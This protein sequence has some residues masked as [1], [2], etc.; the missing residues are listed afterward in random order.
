[1]RYPNDFPALSPVPPEPDDVAVGMLQ[2]APSYG[3]CEVLL[4]SDEHEKR[5]WQLPDEH[6]FKLGEMWRETY[7]DFQ[8]DSKIAYT[9][10]FENRGEAVGV[11]MPHPHGQVYGYP[12]APEKVK[13]EHKNSAKY[14]RK[15]GSCLF[16][17]IL[18]SE[19]NDG[20]RI[21]FENEHFVVY[22]PFFA[23]TVYGVY[24]APKRHV[25]SIAEMTNA[26][27]N[28]L[29]KTVSRCSKMYDNLFDGGKIFPYMMGMYNPLKGAD[30]DFWH[31]HIKFFSVMR[32][33]VKQQFPASSETCVGAYCNP[34][35]PEE[36]AEELRK[37]AVL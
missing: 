25:F 30:K 28:S 35:S 15:N 27:L 4:Y 29:S 6:L 12:F 9:F 2:T 36:K 11:T 18:K 19:R 13:N 14:R 1:M 34:T 5:L 21:I 3:R 16:C 10:I 20:R 33:E 32:S 8:Q 26:E 17:D 37:A 7:L 23:P 31:F 22:L 24:I